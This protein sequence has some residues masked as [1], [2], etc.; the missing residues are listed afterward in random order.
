MDPQNLT[1]EEK[2]LH[3]IRGALGVILAYASLIKSTPGTNSEVSEFAGHIIKSVHHISAV[4]RVQMMMRKLTTGASIDFYAFPVFN[5]ISGIV[6][7]HEAVNPKIN[8]QIVNNLSNPEMNII[9]NADALVFALNDLI[10]NAI[11]AVSNVES[12]LISVILGEE[13]DNISISVKD[14]GIGIEPL[15]LE[16]IW[17]SGFST[18]KSIGGQEQISHGIGLASVLEAVGFM[19]ATINVQSTPGYGTE[20][21]MIL[22]T[23]VNSQT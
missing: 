12:P 23:D 2:I 5:Q 18:T 13:S 11:K 10:S 14:N 20:F 6:R 9:S 15:N 17:E 19:N 4:F 3:G 22:P 1:A 8:F 7:L 21:K 16:K